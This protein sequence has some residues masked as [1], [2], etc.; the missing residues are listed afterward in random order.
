MGARQTLLICCSLAAL[1]TSSYASHIEY[2]V[3]AKFQARTA[4][5]LPAQL[6]DTE[7]QA[8]VN[9]MQLGLT[10]ATKAVVYTSDS[11]CVMPSILADWSEMVVRQR[12][13]GWD[14]RI[15]LSTR[16]GLAALGNKQTLDRYVPL[17]QRLLLAGRTTPAQAFESLKTAAISSPNRLAAISE[18]GRRTITWDGDHLT[19]MIPLRGG[20]SRHAEYRMIDGTSLEIRRFHPRGNLLSCETW[21]PVAVRTEAE[22]PLP[23]WE[24]LLPGSWVLDQRDAS[25]PIH[26]RWKGYGREPA[27]SDAPSVAGTSFKLG[28]MAPG[29][30]MMVGGIGLLV[31][32]TFKRLPSLVGRRTRG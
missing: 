20:H 2:E 12:I 25:Q 29:L 3:K 24:S 5:D 14:D 8:L 22:R 16:E 9:N 15:Y 4:G 31:Y 28:W 26:K 21:K 19:E 32:Q 6:S 17:G 11:Y 1:S 10:G 23:T 27:S 18:S 13:D 7:R 30:A